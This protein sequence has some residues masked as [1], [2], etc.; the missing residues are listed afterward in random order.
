[1]IEYNHR[2]LSRVY[3][4]GTRV[5][6][7]NFDARLAW[8]SGCQLVALNYQTSGKYLWMNE[9][10]FRDNGGCGYVLKPPMLRLN[11]S[12]LNEYKKETHEG[13]RVSLTIISARQLPKPAQHVASPYI[14]AMVQG[15]PSDCCTEK[16][17]VVKENG[18]SPVWNETMAFKVDLP[19]IA[20]LL[21]VVYTELPLTSTG[22]AGVVHTQVVKSAGRQKI[23][24]YALPLHCIQSGYRVVELCSMTGKPIAGCTLFVRIGVETYDTGK[25][26][27]DLLFNDGKQGAGVSSPSAPSPRLPHQLSKANS[28]VPQRK[29]KQPAEIE[30]KRSPSTRSPSQVSMK[31]EKRASSVAQTKA[32]PIYAGGDA[33]GA[34]SVKKAILAAVRAG[35]ISATRKVT[36]LAQNSAELMG[37]ADVEGNTPLHLACAGGKGVIINILLANGAVASSVNKMK[38]TPLHLLL[39]YAKKL[40]RSREQVLNPQERETQEELLPQMDTTSTLK[41]KKEGES[42]LGD[43]SDMMLMQ[44]ASS[45]VRQDP[46]IVDMCDTYGN[47]PLLLSCMYNMLDFTVLFLHFSDCNTDGCNK[48]GVAPLHAAAT[49][50]NTA[51]ID[52][53]L[54]NGADPA[55]GCC[56]SILPAKALFSASQIPDEWINLIRPLPTHVSS[57]GPV[58]LHSIIFE[59]SIPSNAMLP[60]VKIRLGTEETIQSVISKSLRKVK[61]CIVVTNGS[62][63]AS[64]EPS[65]YVLALKKSTWYFGD[66]GL[67]VG[68]C[69][70]IVKKLSRGRQRISMEIIPK[71]FVTL[72]GLSEGPPGEALTTPPLRRSESSSFSSLGGPQLRRST[73]DY[74]LSSKDSPIWMPRKES[75][76]G[77]HYSRSSQAEESKEKSRRK[78]SNM[79]KHRGSLAFTSLY[80]FSS[81]AR[82]RD[83]LQLAAMAKAPTTPQTAIDVSQRYRTRSLSPRASG[84]QQDMATKCLPAFDM[85]LDD[86]FR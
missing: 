35:D 48:C 22:V 77:E 4:K 86:I 13:W 46:N 9:G 58:H 34:G 56:P 23:A 5:D 38:Q 60:M 11:G 42:D 61:S 25:N 20:V 73:S 18:Q 65:E 62:Q 59:V 84:K 76:A 71:Q 19:E 75:L 68:R 28:I 83:A 12:Q 26:G 53:L 54:K 6:S 67:Q 43:P 44:V 36:L 39:V 2:Q 21:F 57:P 50:H 63:H 72:T 33:D 74:A 70:E 27:Y 80:A 82:P 29:R 3:P 32:I 8:L 37:F 17:T 78:P 1:M 64:M 14:V 85:D 55:K 31:D 7:K 30:K 52:L 51:M 49:H 41:T 16:T 10:K 81:T 45:M 24:Y 15:L 79:E 66:I 40:K 69:S 47:S